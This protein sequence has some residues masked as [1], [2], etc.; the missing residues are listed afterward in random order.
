MPLACLAVAYISFQQARKAAVGWGNFV[1]AAFDLFLDDLKDKLAISEGSSQGD[2][3]GDM[4]QKFS[5]AV[6]YVAPE[7][8][9]EKTIKQEQDNSND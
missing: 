9:P 2:S 7:S 1:K 3:E 5:E 4:W 8:L 6:L